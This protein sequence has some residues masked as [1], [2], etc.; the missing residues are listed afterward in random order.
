MGFGHISFSAHDHMVDPL[1]AGLMIRSVQVLSLVMALLSDGVRLSFLLTDRVR[2][3]ASDSTAFRY[4]FRAGSLFLG[5]FQVLFFLN[6]CFSRSGSYSS[7]L[8]FGS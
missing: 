2:R 5:G 3:H 4:A 7:L 1:S 8:A 6:Q